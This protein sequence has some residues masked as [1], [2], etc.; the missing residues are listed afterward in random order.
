MSSSAK[1]LKGRTSQPVI[2]R[3]NSKPTATADMALRHCGILLMTADLREK[4]N[5]MRTSCAP[6]QG[7]I[8]A[9]R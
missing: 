3:H 1:S 7:V 4:H 8:K 9:Q 5:M 6:L 2:S